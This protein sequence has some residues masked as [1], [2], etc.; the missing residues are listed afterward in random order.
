MIRNPCASVTPTSA[1]GAIE[2]VKALA[3]AVRPTSLSLGE[4]LVSV[5]LRRRVARTTK[6]E[7]RFER[8]GSSAPF[9]KLAAMCGLAHDAAAFTG[10]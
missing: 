6:R 4:A 8:L 10:N 5:D 9:P 2:Y 3:S 1:G 7:V